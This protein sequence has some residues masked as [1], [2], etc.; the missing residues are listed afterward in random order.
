MILKAGGQERDKARSCIV[1]QDGLFLQHLLRCK[2][3]YSLYPI[4]DLH[5]DASITQ[6]V[7]VHGNQN[8]TSADTSVRDTR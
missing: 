2:P 3:S 5:I 4:Y 7:Q 1:L 6:M 8:N